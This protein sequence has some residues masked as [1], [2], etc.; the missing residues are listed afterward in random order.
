MSRFTRDEARQITSPKL[1]AQDVFC[2]ACDAP[3]AGRE[4]KF[5]LKYFML[6]KAGRVQKSRRS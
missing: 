4:G 3:F 6:R 2:R 5:V 1:S